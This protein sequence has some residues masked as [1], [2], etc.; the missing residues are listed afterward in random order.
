VM[1]VID[2]CDGDNKAVKILPF[3]LKT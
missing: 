1:V 3:M 2:D